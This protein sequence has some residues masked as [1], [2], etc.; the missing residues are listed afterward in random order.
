MMS[1]PTSYHIR[2]KGQLGPE[3]SEWFDSMT[4]T[5]DEHNETLLSGPV[6]DQA[7]LYGILNKI[8]ALGL[9]LLSVLHETPLSSE[10]RKPPI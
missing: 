10:L 1:D 7:A 9:P 8:Q 5:S 4:I 6:L 2:V 3:W